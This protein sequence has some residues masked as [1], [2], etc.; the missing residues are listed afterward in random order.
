MDSHSCNRRTSMRTRRSGPSPQSKERE[1][2][3]SMRRKKRD[4]DNVTA[5]TS[6]KGRVSV[7]KGS[8]RKSR[9]GK[10][11]GGVH[12]ESMSGTDS[13]AG[14]RPWMNTKVG[15]TVN[16]VDEKCVEGMG[17]YDEQPPLNS[18]DPEKSEPKNDVLLFGYKQLERA[19][20]DGESRLLE[21]EREIGYSEI[22]GIKEN[23]CNSFTQ[24]KMLSTD[25]A[26]ACGLDHVC[27]QNAARLI[28]SVMDGCEVSSTLM[29]GRPLSKT[30][31]EVL[32]EAGED[33]KG[34]SLVTMQPCRGESH[35]ASNNRQNLLTQTVTKPNKVTKTTAPKSA[36]KRKLRS[37]G[38][39]GSGQTVQDENQPK[40]RRSEGLEGNSELNTT[41][42]TKKK[43]VVIDRKNYGDICNN[44]NKQDEQ[45]ADVYD[46]RIYRKLKR[47][48][49][50]LS[51]DVAKSVNGRTNQKG[52][53]R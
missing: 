20:T 30:T 16:E 42:T 51:Y 13:G 25:N 40:K 9:R 41:T 32:L 26:E 10:R 31:G 19:P 45:L 3:S 47:L 28:V 46:I 49:Q 15:N 8:L 5:A 39:G 33:I 17:G 52:S 23:A 4:G 34:E 38:A 43:K 14:G 50:L 1:P 21:V 53:V 18:F 12:V 24:E 35:C 27:I 7:V 36:E 44:R 37:E 48:N 29:S 22:G 11:V 6:S 2:V